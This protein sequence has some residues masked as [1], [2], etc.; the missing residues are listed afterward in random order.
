MLEKR[1]KSILI[2]VSI[3][4]FLIVF[5]SCDSFNVDEGFTVIKVL[6]LET[7]EP[8]N[9]ATIAVKGFLNIDGFAQDVF[10]P[11]APTDELGQTIIPVKNAIPVYGRVSNKTVQLF[12]MISFEG[13]L[14]TV[15]LENVTGA[16]SQG[17]HVMV[18]VV[19]TTAPPPKPP[20]LR[21]V[22]G[23]NPV[24]I[25]VQ[26]YIAEIGVCSNETNK[27]IWE[28][29]NNFSSFPYL[30]V[31]EVGLTPE[32]FTDQLTMFSEGDLP[33]CPVV[34]KSSDPPEGFTIF[35]LPAPSGLDLIRSQESYCVD[36]GGAATTCA[37]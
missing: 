33:D 11:V 25:E 37:K 28:I 22:N 19:S 29:G 2:A 10:L 1:M 27:V 23:S 14:D 12:I 20:T 30:D 31:A 21:A 7:S 36:E 4:L 16:M 26:G 8:V 5:V 18:E 6:N 3:P 35:A 32:G 13:K 9:G 24:Q 34:I 17:E 15:A